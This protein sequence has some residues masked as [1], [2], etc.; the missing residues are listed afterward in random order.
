MALA[1]RSCH[2]GRAGLEPAC[3]SKRV[4]R[5]LRNSSTFTKRNFQAKLDW[6]AGWDAARRW[7]WFFQVKGSSFRLGAFRPRRLLQVRHDIMGVRTF[8]RTAR[9]RAGD[10]PP[11]G[12]TTQT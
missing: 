2:R 10:S 11:A 12:N 4:T 6:A 3:F 7:S 9:I 5:K 1:H 8:L